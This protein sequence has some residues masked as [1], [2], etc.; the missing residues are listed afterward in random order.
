MAVLQ[1][2]SV[3]VVGGLG[4]YIAWRQW[5][6]AHD[7]LKPELFDRRLA[8]YRQ[9]NDA[10]A[11]I[12]RTGKATS[13]DAMRFQ[14]AMYDMRY[15]FDKWTEDRVRDVYLAMTAKAALDA[16]LEKADDREKAVQKSGELFQSIIDGITKDVPERMEKFMRFDR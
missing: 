15:L 3:L 5:R 13:D 8:A 1:A 12:V 4:A 14:R 2:L 10:I 6:T 16:Q 7:K 11:P 9:L